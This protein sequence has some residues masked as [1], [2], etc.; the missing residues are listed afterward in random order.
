MPRF[1]KD[2]ADQAP[3]RSRPSSRSPSETAPKPST[4]GAVA[5]VGR[6]MT[7]RISLKGKVAV[8]TGAAPAGWGGRTSNF[9][10]NAVPESW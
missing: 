7:E 1:L 4:L 6:E 10:P 9:S 8:V 3:N 5:I 2:L